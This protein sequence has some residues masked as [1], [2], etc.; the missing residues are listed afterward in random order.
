MTAL[1]TGLAA[2][3]GALLARPRRHPS[4][5]HRAPRRVRH[6]ARNGL[7]QIRLAVLLLSALAVKHFETGIAVYAVTVPTR[8]LRGAL[9]ADDAHGRV[10]REAQPLMVD[11]LPAHVDRDIAV[12]AVEVVALGS[13]SLQ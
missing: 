7:Q 13:C 5:T 10:L 9:R 2:L 12:V 1:H 4:D 8:H 6:A 11:S 3:V